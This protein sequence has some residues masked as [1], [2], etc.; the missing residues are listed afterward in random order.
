MRFFR[1]RGGDRRGTSPTRDGTDA[2]VGGEPRGSLLSEIDELMQRNRA[3]RDVEVERR[4][5][6]ARNE[7]VR[8]L[9]GETPPR[10]GP[11]TRSDGVPIRQG[12][13]VIPAERMDA[14]GVS[15]AI[16][17][18]GCVHVPGFVSR[19]RADRLAGG[20]D[21]TFAAHDSRDGASSETGDDGWYEPFRLPGWKP[22]VGRQWNR[23]SD[24]I[25]AAD[26]PRFMFELSETFE[27][28]GLRPM[29]TEYLGQ[30]PVLS[31]NKSVLRRVSPLTAGADWHQDGAFMGKDI[32]SLNVWLTLTPCGREAPGMDI[33]PRRLDDIVETGTEGA[34]F[35]WSVAPA[36]VD[37]VAGEAGVTRPLFE[38]GDALLFDH[39]FLH[40]TASDPAMTRDRYAIET[41]FFAP[42]AYPSEH[43][44]LVL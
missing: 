37:G 44:P 31:V 30:R 38:A 36:A 26:S 8:E 1:P 5:V 40:R 4:L 3:R 28:V 39:L 29:L 18:H 12:I 35:D 20:I 17:S 42:S 14:A 13:P 9:N 24:A 6:R 2:E 22:G 21:R 7:A 10:A 11:A 15:A 27:E 33:V 43:V 34:N 32:R 25:W 16:R 19:S 23:D 41:W